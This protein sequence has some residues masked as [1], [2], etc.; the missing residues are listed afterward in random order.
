MLTH[1]NKYKLKKLRKLFYGIL[2]VISLVA[3]LLVHSYKS[4]T[5]LR[6]LST[7]FNANKESK[8]CMRMNLETRISKP[9]IAF[10]FG[11]GRTANQLC[12]FA[13]GYALWRQFGILNY[14]NA[15]QYEKLVK[16]FDLPVTLNENDDNAS[17]YVWNEG[18]YLKIKIS[19]K[20]HSTRRIS[21]CNESF[22]YVN[23]GVNF[24][25]K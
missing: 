14:I 7:Y 18:E 15:N 9:S 13:S 21:N 11:G 1:L 20:N 3:L 12:E 16:F 10:S 23:L 6:N 24:Q 25:D 19:E 8:T 4:Y 22:V 5:K 2:I 17:Y